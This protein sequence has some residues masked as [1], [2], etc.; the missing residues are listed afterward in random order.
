MDCHI[1]SIPLSKELRPNE[2]KNFIRNLNGT[3]GVE[4]NQYSLYGSFT[5][6]NRLRFQVQTEKKQNLFTETRLNTVHTGVFT[7]QSKQYKYN[8]GPS[9]SESR[10][11]DNQKQLTDK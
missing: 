11:L 10:F 7:Y 8:T 9:K 3:N 2:C 1:K 5:Y 4:L 6:F